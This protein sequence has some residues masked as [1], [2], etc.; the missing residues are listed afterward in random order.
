MPKSEKKKGGGSKLNKTQTVTLRLDPRLRYLTDLA[1][2]TQRRT[3]SAFIEWAIEQ[4][5]REIVVKFGDNDQRTLADE[6]SK[7]WDVDE[8]D[9]L[10]KLAMNYPGLLTHDEQAIWKLIIENDAFWDSSYS[11]K[12]DSMMMEKKI[13]YRLIRELWDTLKAVA[14][15][16][17]NIGELQSHLSNISAIDDGFDD[18]N[19][20]AED[21]AKKWDAD[22]KIRAEFGTYERYESFMKHASNIRIKHRMR[23]DR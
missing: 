1:A 6:A 11:T 8:A 15:G 2:R 18:P 7:L 19:L 13:K 5:M 14:K 9:R 21:R 20:N 3:T 17:A 12:W 23:T 16:D 22:P 10:A 4:S